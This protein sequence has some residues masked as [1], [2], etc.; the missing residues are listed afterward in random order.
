MACLLVVVLP[1]VCDDSGYRS[2]S[3]WICIGECLKLLIEVP[4]NNTFDGHGRCRDCVCA[5]QS[6]YK[7]EDE[8]PKPAK[9]IATAARTSST[10]Q[11]RLKYREVSNLMRLTLRQFT[12]KMAR[13]KAGHQQIGP[14]KCLLRHVHPND[15]PS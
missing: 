6:G 1:L 14:C 7:T 12:E 9:S 4:E 11:F 3:I 10:L 15:L 2:Y 13:S 5:E 8:A